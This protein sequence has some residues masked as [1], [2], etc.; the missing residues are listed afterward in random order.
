MQTIKSQ[1][2]ITATEPTSGINAV[3]PTSRIDSTQRTC[4]TRSSQS[5]RNPYFVGNFPRNSICGYTGHL[6]G[7]YP[8][9][10]YGA[11]PHRLL[12]KINTPPTR[13]VRSSDGYRPG[14][15]VVGYTG[16]VPYKQ[17]GNIFGE[18]FS[19]SNFSSQK[20]QRPL[21]S[22]HRGRVGRIMEEFHRMSPSSDHGNYAMYKGIS[23]DYCKKH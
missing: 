20:L 1:R 9:G 3:I 18:T 8:E 21:D 13:R 23:N 16:F 15:D 2:S 10:K 6:P 14:L 11:S 7:I 22:S 4:S 12:C 19:K 5:Q 17:A